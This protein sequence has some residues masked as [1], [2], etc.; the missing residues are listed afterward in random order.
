MLALTKGAIPNDF[1]HQPIFVGYLKALFST[2]ISSIGLLS[3]TEDPLNLKMWAHYGGNSTGICLAFDRN[4]NNILGSKST[5]KV[6]YMT[7]RPKIT[8]HDRHN[9]IEEI[10]FTKS[11]ILKYEKEWRTYQEE[12]DKSYPFPGKLR[13]ILFGLNCHHDTVELTKNIFGTNVD[14]ED[15][16]IGRDYTIRSDKG[17]KH[18][19]SQVDLKW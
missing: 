15:I 1:I 19:I 8:L 7:K 18:P 16:Y 3:L 10:I 9:R 4:P 5:R 12:G 14:Y 13:R 11:Y 6:K 2:I 17:L